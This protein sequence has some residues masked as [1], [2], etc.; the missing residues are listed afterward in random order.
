MSK[1][2]FSIVTRSV[3]EADH[4]AKKYG[5]KLLETEAGEPGHVKATYQ[6]RKVKSR[7]L[8]RWIVRRVNYCPKHPPVM[9]GAET[10]GWALSDVFS[11]MHRE[12]WQILRAQI[13]PE[14]E[15]TAVFEATLGDMA[16]AYSITREG[17]QY[18]EAW[19]DTFGEQKLADF[20]EG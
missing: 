11:H 7:V 18:P 16:A 2:A 5:I 20:I 17:A 1:N 19:P 4:Y 15:Y 3:R 13:D 10:F 9:I 14:L 12:G 6:A 8:K